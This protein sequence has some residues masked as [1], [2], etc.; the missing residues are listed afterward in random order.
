MS[1]VKMKLR[2][3]RK[4]IM[5]IRYYLACFWWNRRK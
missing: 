3:E 4:I 5:V 1:R 2:N